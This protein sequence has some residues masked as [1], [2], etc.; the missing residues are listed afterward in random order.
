[1]WISSKRDM[2]EWS[3]KREVLRPRHVGR[4]GNL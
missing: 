1:V 4:G 3:P 2:T